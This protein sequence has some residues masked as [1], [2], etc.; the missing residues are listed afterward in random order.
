MTLPNKKLLHYSGGGA[1]FTPTNPRGISPTLIE[2][3]WAW[4]FDEFE[5]IAVHG[6]ERDILWMPFGGDAV[7]KLW[8]TNNGV[9]TQIETGLRVEQFSLAKQAGYDNLCDTFTAEAKKFVDKGRELQVYL[10]CILGAPEWDENTTT[11]K[12]QFRRL[13]LELKPYVDAGCSIAFDLSCG[14]PKEH[15]FFDYMQRLKKRGTK[16]YIETWPAR[17]FEHL[18]HFDCINMTTHFRNWTEAMIQPREPDPKNGFAGLIN[19]D[20]LTGERQVWLV[21]ETVL[22]EKGITDWPLTAAMWTKA[23]HAL[24]AN[25]W[26]DSIAL[27]MNYFLHGGGKVADLWPDWKGFVK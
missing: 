25:P 13:D 5:K 14:T 6:I 17:G 18:R 11:V 16:V 4:Q 20:D 1:A 15:W 9:H 7:R 12:E 8:V 2:K 3:G 19:P 24:L 26:V 21:I 27:K 23:T 22:N 10:G